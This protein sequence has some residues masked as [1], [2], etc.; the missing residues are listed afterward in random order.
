MQNASWVAWFK[1]QVDYGRSLG[2]GVS[3]C[4]RAHCFRA[5][6]SERFAACISECVPPR[7][8]LYERVRAR[9]SRYTL[10]QHNGW[11]ESVPPAEQVL[12]PGG[13]R[14]GIACFATDWHAAYRAS[15]LAFAAEVGLVGVETD[16]QVRAT[17]W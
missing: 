6:I 8:L 11:G 5:C 15:V 1:A 4:A 12:L 3:A 17:R 16:G 13:G 14:G 10:M 7:T 9:E 2:V